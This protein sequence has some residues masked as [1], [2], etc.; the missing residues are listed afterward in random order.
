MSTLTQAFYDNNK[1]IVKLT[2]ANFKN[3]VLKSDEIWLIEFYAPWCGH[4]KNLAPE[5]EKA[6]KALKGVVKVGAVDMTTDQSVG[7]P[8]N[9]QGFPTIKLFGLDKKKIVDYN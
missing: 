1:N 5:W 8:Y 9:I 4:C 7:Q 6:A 2:E 3:E